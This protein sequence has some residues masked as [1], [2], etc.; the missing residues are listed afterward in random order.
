MQPSMEYNR[1]APFLAR[2]R[3]WKPSVRNEREEGDGG[4]R[5]NRRKGKK[6]R[7]A[8][9]FTGVVGTGGG[10]SSWGRI[11]RTSLVRT[12]IGA[13]LSIRLRKKNQGVEQSDSLR[14]VV[15]RSCDKSL[16]PTIR[17]TVLDRRSR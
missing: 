6:R 7:Y 9:P 4:R 8:N 14:P 12:I 3:R 16:S 2:S 5:R 17:G 11:E 15:L 13:K 10:Q 1:A